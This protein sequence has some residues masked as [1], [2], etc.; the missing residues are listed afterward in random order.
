MNKNDNDSKNIRPAVVYI[1]NILSKKE[2]LAHSDWK[3][4]S[5]KN[6]IILFI[7]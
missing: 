5:V 6:Q 2:E 3:S 7:L 1:K 4:V